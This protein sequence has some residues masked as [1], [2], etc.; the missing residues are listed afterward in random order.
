[1]VGL[2]ERSPYV[3]PDALSGTTKRLQIQNLLPRSGAH[4]QRAEYLPF[5]N[6]QVDWSDTMLIYGSP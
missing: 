2:N 4:S 5:A 6:G 3:G 1:M